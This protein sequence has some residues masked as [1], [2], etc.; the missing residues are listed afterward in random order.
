[1]RVER[2]SHA[3]AADW[4]GMREALWPTGG[5]HGTH[6]QDIARLLADPGN[7]INLIA[8]QE[9]GAALGFAEASLRHD[10]V[11]GCD[12]S[13]VAFLE[14]IYV[15]PEARG[16]GVAR[17][18]IAT[19]E[20]WARSQGATELASDAALD[21]IGSHGMHNA[22]GFAETQRVVFFKKALGA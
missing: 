20:A 7:T 13:P 21:N 2:V 14:G 17:A 3:D 15:T 16:Q 6:A 12:S 19:I 10:Y 9:G 11:N 8:R 5:D 22:L 18:L 4:A 1:M